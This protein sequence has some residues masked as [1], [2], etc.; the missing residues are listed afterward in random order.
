MLVGILL[1]ILVAFVSSISAECDVSTI[2]DAQKDLA[3]RVCHLEDE[4]SVVQRALQ[5]VMQRT[6]ITLD[7][8]APILNKRK[9]EFIRFGKRSGEVDKRKNEFIR[10]GKR[11]NEFI[12][13]G[14]SDPALYDDVSMEKRKNEFIRFG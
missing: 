7:D 5:E 9:N 1:A 10:F 8:A 13:F 12:R 6:D 11:K 14:R 2:P 3:L 4:L